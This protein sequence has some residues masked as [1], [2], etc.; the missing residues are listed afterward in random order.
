MISIK[1]KPI[2]V[3]NYNMNKEING[4]ELNQILCNY[5]IFLQNIHLIFYP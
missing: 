5:R 1:A 4:D 3:Y 2:K